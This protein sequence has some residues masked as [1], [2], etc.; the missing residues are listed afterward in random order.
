MRT[1]SSLVK[2]LTVSKSDLGGGDAMW[3]NEMS[4]QEVAAVIE[5][6][7]EQKS[8]YP[9][10]WNDFVETPQHDKRIEEYRKR[11]YELD[12]LVNRPGNS[13]PTAVTELR[14]IIETLKSAPAR[15]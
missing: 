4:T 9:Q 5:R 3:K 15:S 2:R 7:L 1:P 13:D 11:C 14:S 8:L 10:E 6:F 12:S